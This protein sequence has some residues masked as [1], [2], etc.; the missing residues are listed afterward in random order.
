MLFYDFEVFKYDWLVCAIDPIKQ[1]EFVI[2]NSKDDLQKLYNE[3]KKDVWCGYNSRNYDQW[4][5]KA[6]LCGFNPKAMNDWIIVD[7]KKGHEFSSLLYRIKLNDYDVMPNIPVSL[8]A[9]EGFLG[10]NIHE[11][12]VP[13]DID[14]KLTQT[15]IAETIDYCRDDV[16]NLIDVFIQRKSEFDS[17]FALVKEFNLPLSSIGKTQAQLAAQILG[18][19]RVKLKDEWEIRMPECLQL[20]KYQYVADWFMNPENHNEDFKLETQIGG[21]DSVVGW[22][23]LH[24]GIKKFVYECKDDEIILDADIGQMYPN[25]MIHY[26]LQSRGVKNKKKLPEILETSMRLKREGKKKEREP[27]KR[28]CNIVYGAEGDRFNPMYDALHRKLVCIY[29]QV[30]MIDL[31]DKIEDIIKCLNHNTDGIFFV[32]KKKDI[33]ELKRRIGEWE[34]RTHLVME[35]DEF[36]KFVSKDVNNYVAVRPDGSYH[37]KGAY[38]KELNPLDYDL[39][40]VN[41]AVKNYLLYNKPVE[42]TIGQCN[43]FIEFQKIVKLSSKYSWVEHEQTAGNIRYDNKAYRVFA[44]S[45]PNDGRLLKCKY[46]DTVDKLTGE[47]LTTR[48]KPDKFGNTPEHCFIYN[49]SVIGVD[50]PAK[51]DKTWYIDLAH[52][53]IKDF[54]G[55]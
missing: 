42:I 21:I 8:K 51:L 44:S 43:D 34:K 27:Y 15:E 41:E 54:I 22:G 47:V 2:V 4:I 6:I 48:I 28:I 39:P 9:L 20:G 49:D 23:G 36:M 1:E 31:I 5:L 3:Y 26:D 14:R 55:E 38:V 12:S 52:K 40:I 46:V 32:V 13:F 30:L 25:I 45:D 19:Q 18:A 16:M 53:R 29:G 10:K 17:Q 7:K 50:I 37:A 33:P 24:G 11:T 35:Y